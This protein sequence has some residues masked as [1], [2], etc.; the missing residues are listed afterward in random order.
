MTRLVLVGVSVRALAEPLPGRARA[1]LGVDFFGDRDREHSVETYALG[2]DLGL[3]ASASGLAAAARRLRADAVVYCA[4]LENHPDVVAWLAQGCEVLGNGADVLRDVRDPGRLRDVCREAGIAYPAT[5]LPGE[6]HA[7]DPRERWLVKRVRSGGGHGVTPWRGARAAPGHVLQ[8]F[9]DG[10]PAS[11]AFAADGRDC[12][13]FG[14]CEQ[15]VGLRAFGASGFTWCGNILPF[16]ASPPEAGD[17][18]AQVTRLAEE[19]TRRFGLRGVNGADVIVTRDG[20]GLPGVCLLEVNPRY[21]ASMELVQWG[22]GL[23]VL[24]LHLEACAGRL[25]EARAAAGPSVF[26]GKAVVYA[27]DAVTVPSTDTWRGRSRRD[28]PYEGQRVARGHPVCTVLAEGG[29]REECLRLLEQ[30]ADDVYRE[31]T[32]PRAGDERTFRTFDLIGKA[33]R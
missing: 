22:R 25:P 21:S 28:V 26:W 30:R 33:V 23:D 31:S 1:A 10:T 11:V 15:L 24:G 9:V 18:L 17:L 14:F 2:R 7:A 5:L 8:R 16:A 13:V 20:E 27:R 12:R 4:N 29:S 6:E 3:P 32:R 19:L